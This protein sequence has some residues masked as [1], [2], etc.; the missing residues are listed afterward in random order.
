MTRLRS[1]AAFLAFLATMSLLG[2]AAWAGPQWCEED[3]EFLVNGSIVDVTTLFPASYATYVKGSVNFDMQVPSNVVAYAVS[4]PGTI[5]VTASISRTLPAY[6]GI[7]KIPVVVTVSM[8][9]TTSFQT[10]T[11]VTGTQGLLVSGIY[12]TSTKPTYAK[13]SMYGT[14]LWSWDD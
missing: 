1:I 7:G 12:G 6:Y 8:S 4:L 3:P 2:S 9:A 11:Q 14:S 13:F 5:P 10:Y